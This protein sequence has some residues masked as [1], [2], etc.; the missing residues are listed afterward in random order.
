VHR[1]LKP[2]N[3]MLGPYGE[4]LVMD[5]G[6]AKSVGEAATSEGDG[7]SPSP[8]P[9]AEELTATGVVLGTPQYMSPEQARGE[10]VGPAGDI[11]G[12]GLILYAILTGKSAFEE[13]SFRGVDP[14][15]A[16][17]EAAIVP[18]RRREPGLPPALEA[19]CL[20]ALAARPEG[21]Y[22]TARALADDVTRWLGGEPVTAWREPVSMKA[23]RWARRHR[24]AVAAVLVALVAGA[25]GLGAVAAV[26]ARAHVRLKAALA[27]S[28]ESRK[29]YE[30]M[31]DLLV[32]AVHSQD[33]LL[34]GQKV[35]LVLVDELD[36]ASKRL[37]QGYV[38]PPAK[39]GVLLDALGQTYRALGLYD[40]ALSLH[41]RARDVLEA[42]LGPDHP[43]TLK[44]RSYLANAYRNAGR[45][46]ETIAMHE[47]TLERREAL[48]GPDHPD[49]LTNRGDLGNAYA[50]A[51]RPTE[52]IAL[53]KAT[54]ERREALLGPDHP[55]TLASH[56]FLAN[57]YLIAG[58]WDEAVARH[59]ATL[60]R[61][62]AKL[63]PDH[64]DTLASR[65]NLADAYRAAGRT[66]E[67]IALHEATLSL[68]EARLGPD[69]LDT[70]RSR[71]SLAIAYAVAGR[72]SDAIPLFEAVLMWQEAKLGPDHPDTLA[73]RLNLADAYRAAGRPSEAIPLCQATLKRK[74][75]KL[76]PDHPDTLHCR[77]LL[78]SAYDS[79]GRGAEAE[80]L[81]R[82]VLAR[83][84]K[85][86]PLDSHLLAD[87]LAALARNLMEQSRWSEAEPLSR[88][89]LTIRAKATPDDWR[90][91]EA[92]SLLGGALMNRGRPSEAR[93]L[94]VAGY[95][96]M[97][98]REP[99][100]TVLER[101]RLREAAERVVHLY[102]TWGRPEE[103]TAWK[104]KV[105]MPDLPVDVFAGP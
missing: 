38:G 13:S 36:R 55:L 104:T 9:E 6:L 21:R 28:E 26:Q 19:V 11:F 15:Q 43:A 7:G 77:R 98:A 84:R 93:P 87:D 83:R 45:L 44:N 20:K 73:C 78:A 86:V 94:V 12:L 4:T 66:S 2:S 48:L 47:A 50:V 39:Q 16:V 5:W 31:M 51:G 72:L 85:A 71:G 27:G 62:A 54:L 105:G 88:E 41:A 34:D 52:A 8:A 90:R 99:R 57:A 67:A 58:R 91:Y 70:L 74:E 102:E 97:K 17:R 82:D 61:R 53:H 75:M 1:D 46:D 89:A 49:T 80:R 18:P 22:T 96:E 59:E 32:Q 69:H 40:Q 76:G 42:A 33:P 101:P 92:M 95:E 79:L 81:Y 37:D 103:A 3:V 24:T 25:A 100:I 63:S 29:Q 56:F 30:E 68:R 23:R 64:P 14:L 35:R 10:P 65:H 60:N